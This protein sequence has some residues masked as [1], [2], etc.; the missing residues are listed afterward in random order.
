MVVD[1]GLP[2]RDLLAALTEAKPPVVDDI[3]LF[4]VYRGPGIGPGKKSLAILVL[5]QD[6][7]RTLT[8]AEIDATVGAL[9]RV[10]V[11][12][13]GATLRQ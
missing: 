1:D 12:R 6:T 4:D 9:L 5:I 7:E 10:A 11:D 13:F 8:D 2:A 3:R